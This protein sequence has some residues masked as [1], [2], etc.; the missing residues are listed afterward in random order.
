M[1]T[2]TV[3]NIVTNCAVLVVLLFL[4]TSSFV[5]AQSSKSQSLINEIKAELPGRQKEIAEKCD[6]AAV[7]VEVDFAS[8]GDNSDALLRVPQLGLKETANGFRRFCT[9]SNNTS[10]PDAAK[11]GALKAK[12]KRIVLKHVQKQEEKKVSLQSGGVVLI[13]MKFDQPLGGGISYTELAAKLA[14]IL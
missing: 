5:C 2:M 7:I 11:V 1:K 10:Q 13:E 12:V 8:F 6:G 9:D 4:A 14:D 3:K